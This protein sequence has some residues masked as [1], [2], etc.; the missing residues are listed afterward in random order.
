METRSQKR[1]KELAIYDVN[2]DFDDASKE[3]NKNKIKLG[4]GT[5][6]YR[7]EPRSSERLLT[8]KGV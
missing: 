2:I 6:K 7:R 1:Y 3:W 5:Y 8:R 4:N